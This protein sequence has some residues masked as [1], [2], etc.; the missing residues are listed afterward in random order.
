V[1][2]R[3][4]SRQVSALDRIRASA[5]SVPAS[6]V[7]GAAIPLLFLHRTYQPTLAI[8][9][10][11]TTVDVTLAD[12]AVAAV[13]VAAGF[14]ARR[15]GLRPLRAGR[16]VYGA[17]AALIVLV[18]VSLT[19]PAIMDETYDWQ[20]HL[21]SAAKFSWY[22]ALA[23]AV[24]LL[25]ERRRDLDVL[26]KALVLWSG[27]ATGWGLLQFLGLVNE[28][29]GKRPGQREPSFVGIHD[30]AALSGA[31]LALGLAGL[32]LGPRRPLAQRWSIAALVV[33][34]L[35]LVVSGALTGV[36]GVW[37]AA[38]AILLL[39]RR[40]RPLGIRPVLATLAILVVVSVG[41]ATMRAEAIG[42]FAEF[43][44]IRDKTAQTGVESYSHRTLLA[45]IG[46]KIWLDHPIAGVGFQG[47]SERWAYEP[48]LEAA[49]RR[50]PD[51][52]DEAFPSP[53][54]EWGVQNLYVQVL[55]DF[56]LLGFAILLALFGAAFAT[57]IRGAR[58]SPVPLLGLALLLVA[59]GVW[60]GIGLV[61]GIPV[62][63]L[64]WLAL[65]LVTTRV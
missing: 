22:A 64:T 9:F 43:L 65:G 6:A 28:F 37:V 13:V 17:A 41:T 15:R 16:A 45:Y 46:A 32:A 20:A 29:E 18:F 27:A 63:A 14:Q 49:H 44:G 30:F 56:G 36:G 19:Y 3:S 58:A 54:H 48:H 50:F 33:G 51:Q 26:L 2:A 57:A 42:R 62:A 38:A 55:A 53:E 31:A 59:A 21:V 24:P 34:G 7:L 35:G 61:P 23:V 1:A 4:T 52:P 25:V 11:G 5:L 10:G 39:A 40:I 60:A 8:P 12:W 47:S